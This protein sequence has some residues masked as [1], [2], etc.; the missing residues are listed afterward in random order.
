MLCYYFLFCANLKLKWV[1]SYP[2]DMRPFISGPLGRLHILKPIKGTN[3][4]HVRARAGLP[5]PVLHHDNITHPQELEF[6]SSAGKAEENVRQQGTS[7]ADK[8]CSN[9]SL[10]ILADVGGFVPV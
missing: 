3:G 1:R 9:V 7:I 4:Y 8:A 5:I 2:M 10:C 6:C